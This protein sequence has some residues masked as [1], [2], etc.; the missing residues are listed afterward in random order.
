MRGNS[1]VARMAPGISPHARYAKTSEVARVVGVDS[2]TIR[3]WCE[4]GSVLARK[5]PGD[6]WRIEV[7]AAGWPLEPDDDD[8]DLAGAE[9]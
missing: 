3:R 5:T 7:D 6:E 8:D 2:A 1:Y 4:Q 9:G